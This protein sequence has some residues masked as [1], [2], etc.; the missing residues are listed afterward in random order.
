MT[1]DID[2]YQDSGALTSGRGAVTTLI[3]NIGWKT[4]GSNEETTYAQAPII[5]PTTTPIANSYEYYTFFKLSGTYIKGSRVKITI[6]GNPNG[7]SEDGYAT[8]GTGVKLFYRLVDTYETPDSVD[9]GDLVYYDG[10]TIA[11]YPKLSMF[12]PQ[13]GA[14]Y[15]QYLDENTTYYT[16]YLLTRILVEQ[17]STFGNIGDVSFN[18]TVDEYESTDT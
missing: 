8:V 7:S 5:R 18:C 13:S 3:T 16:Q 12:G 6:A 10:T 9:D 15:H 1:I 2:H 11:L 4:A 14:T 17:G